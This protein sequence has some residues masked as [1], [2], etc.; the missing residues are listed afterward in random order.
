MKPNLI[1]KTGETLRVSVIIPTYN[2]AEYLSQALKSVFDQSLSPFEVI[3]IDDGSTDNTPEVVRAFEPG[4]RY[5][6][7]DH[8]RG[9][10]AARNLGLE[11]A[12]GEVIAWLDA[13][14]LW[15]PDFLGTIIPMLETVEGLDGVYTGL[16]R[17]DADGNLL[18]QASQTVVSPPDLYSVL[19]ED[20]FI[21]ISTFVARKRCFERVGNFDTQFDI[22]EDY[23]MFLRLATTF[24][25]AGVPTPLVRYRVHEHNTVKDTAAF[26]QFRLALAQKHFGKLEGDAR[27]WSVERRCAHAYAF[28]SVAL[29]CIQDGQPDRGWRFLEKATLIWPDLLGRLDTFYEL[30]CG[31]QPR[32]YRGHANLL[33]IEGNGTEMLNRLDNLFAKADP[34]L[35]PMRRRAYGNAHLAL[36]LL[37]DL[38]SRPLVARRYLLRAAITH[39]NLLVTSQLPRKLIKTCLG[40]RA[41]EAMSQLKDWWT[42]Q[43]FGTSFR[44]FWF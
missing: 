33:D 20:C 11:V 38:A 3:V 13:D 23:D 35:K 18:P 7:H 5:F 43:I 29:K 17:I 26:C 24:T 4:I 15:E 1:F 32:G 9:V 37:S 42:D 22:C 27:T 12:R 39:P 21:Q 25:I 44:A 34:T 36:G 10:S 19:I 28:R 30:A 2:R 41:I 14:D 31:D 40:A 16:V 6:R 8:N